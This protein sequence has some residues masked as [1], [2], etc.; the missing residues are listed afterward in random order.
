MGLMQLTASCPDGYIGGGRD[1]RRYPCDLHR[2]V[3]ES[4]TDCKQHVAF[5]RS[6]VVLQPSLPSQES[7]QGLYIQCGQI[8][9]H[10]LDFVSF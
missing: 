8:L 4:S 6:L 10:A 2:R 7:T 1:E 3:Q 5:I 9:L